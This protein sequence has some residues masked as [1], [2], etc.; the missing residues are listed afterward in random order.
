M[1]TANTSEAMTRAGW[2]A[3]RRIDDSIIQTWERTLLAEGFQMF[4][5]AR[6]AL[7]EFGGLRHVAPRVAG[8]DFAPLS[9]CF[10]PTLAVGEYD[11]ICAYES[12]LSSM[13]FPLG[14]VA[15]GHAFIV[16]DERGGVYLL[17]DG[18]MRIGSTIGE[19]IETMVD[20]GAGHPAVEQ[21]E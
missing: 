3:S 18:V 21:P 1:W 11:R 15:D 17:M 6:Q 16:I 12:A 10:D 5:S 8:V 7:L 20:G 4:P 14:E 9:F 19:A 13:L 2:T